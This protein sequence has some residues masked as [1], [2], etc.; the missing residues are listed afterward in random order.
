MMLLSRILLIVLI[1]SFLP[2]IGE[3]A[4]R[5][6]RKKQPASS[7]AALLIPLSY[8]QLITENKTLS[9]H[10]SKVMALAYSPDGSR[11]VSGGDDK[12][13]I[14]WDVQSGEQAWTI[15][16][17]PDRVTNIAFCGSGEVLALTTKGENIHLVNALTGTYITGFRAKKDVQSLACSP[18]GQILAAAV[19]KGVVIWNLDNLRMP[20]AGA[21][22]SENSEENGGYFSWLKRKGDTKKNDEQARADKAIIKTLPGGDQ[23]VLSIAFNASGG[24]LAMG[25]KDKQISIW[26]VRQWSRTKTLTGFEKEI[27][28]LA[29]SPDGGRLAAVEDKQKILMWDLF[30]KPSPRLLSSERDDITGLAF[31]TDGALLVTTGKKRTVFWS[32]S[33]YR[34]L[35]VLS[36][37]KQEPL[38]VTCSPD[39][40][41]LAI[42]GEDKLVH[43]WNLPGI[44][45]LAASGTARGNALTTLDQE[46]D[47]RI[48][49]LYSKKNEFESS[50][51]YG[52]RLKQAKADEQALRNEYA[53]RR[54]ALASQLEQ[55]EGRLK[56]Q[57]Y[58]YNGKGD[59]GRYDADQHQ[60]H[61][62]LGGVP[63]A[64]PVP[65]R[66]A[67]ELA[68]RRESLFFSGM[69]RY[70]DPQRGELV[71]GALVDQA[72][73][74][75][76]PFGRQVAG[77]ENQKA[78]SAPMTALPVVVN[79]RKAAPN[80]EIVSVVLVEPSGNNALDAGERGS[81]R[82]VLRNSGS[83][84]AD[85]VVIDLRADGVTPLPATLSVAERTV[86]GDLGPKQSRTIDVP[87]IAAEGVPGREMRLQVAALEAGGFDAQPVLLDF[88]VKALIPPDLQVARIEISDA[89]GKR[90]ISKGKE[91]NVV[92]AVQN[93]GKGA[94]RGVKV[95][96]DSSDP[97][98][99][100]FG[101]SEVVLGVL[102]P[103]ESKRAS[104]TIAVTQRYTG[105]KTLPV[106]FQISEERPRFS[107]KP[108]LQLVLNKE[109]PEVRL[110]TVKERDT[111]PVAAVQDD[112]GMV[113]LLAVTRRAFNDRDLAL[114]IGIERY[115]NVPKSDF[116]YNDARSIKAYLLSLGFAERNIEF[117]ADERATLSAIRKSV[118]SWLP[119]HVKPG[120][121]IFFYYSGHGAPDPA[122]GEA[123]IVPYDG[124]PSYLN[125]TGY[126]VK[127]LYEKLGAAKATE[128]IVVMDS[129]FSGSGGRSVLAKG[130]RPLVLMADTLVIP[131]GMAILASTQGSQISTSFEEKEHGVFTYYFLKALK[132]GKGD[133]DAVYRYLKPLVEDTAKGQNVS[134]S[135]VLNMGTHETIGSFR[136]LTE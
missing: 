59:L 78:A 71:N 1:L 11:L 105:P 87:I 96:L 30:G 122:T 82:V 127:R 77:I 72:S 110:V 130:A 113:P 119:N 52:E 134:Q 81:I 85:G 75:R 126:P 32:T 129:C 10:S 61:A 109:A 125:D 118:E 76:F 83:G 48:K 40:T 26:D 6:S 36:D 51:Q 66:V 112:I 92:I 55:Q 35:H 57:Y 95:R 93:S 18:S 98:I 73:G 104:F 33:S 65:A 101:D 37:E 69:I 131:P 128:V 88:S 9:G 116:A 114:V 31:S 63:I 102:K 74:E 14:A 79:E 56:R 39:N 121:R 60:F 41:G 16:N 107:I 44:I 70:H 22:E 123:F 117:L 94:A 13:L 12:V 64:V 49:A 68:G 97:Q 124:D 20:M 8:D 136:L 5:P 53:A 103:G 106:S 47:G 29:F 15:K 84:G 50:R 58:P 43:L 38:A 99:K 45:S 4:E 91:S 23:D 54:S 27:R 62:T 108:Q 100:L 90:V 86:V 132:E 89:E 3:T 19:D 28:T 46:R 120:S 67:Q 135:P 2:D 80:L 115:Q 133:I 21:S 7:S 25:G 17:L 111:A 24:Y 42:A 34:E